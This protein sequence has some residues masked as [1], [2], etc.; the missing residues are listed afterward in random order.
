MALRDR[1]RYLDHQAPCWENKKIHEHLGECLLLLEAR[2]A[3]R[4]G[5][6]IPAV[7]ANDL[8]QMTACSYCLHKGC[9]GECGHG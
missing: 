1:I 7:D 3:R 5:R 2:A 4:H 8:E 6:P 9:K